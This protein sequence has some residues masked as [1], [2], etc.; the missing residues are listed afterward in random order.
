MIALVPA[1][2]GSKGL[3]R[4]NILPLAGVPLIVHTLKC[5]LAATEISRVVVSTDDE[6]IASVAADIEGVEVPFMRPAELAADTA[7]AID[8]YLHAAEALGV[9][10]LCVLLP[11]APLRTPEDI[12]ACIRLFRAQKAEVV[13]SVNEAKP[14]AWQQRMNLGGQLAPV[15]GIVPSIDNR[16]GYGVTVIPNGAIYVLNMPSLAR[17]RSYFGAKS[18]GHL[19]PAS[20]SVDIDDADDFTVAEALLAYRGTA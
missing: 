9:G 12:D 17:T 5:A 4:K 7:S 14:A 2:G 10:E 13:M 18:L 1:R 6:E 20:R 16:Q 11:T 8:A 3:P 15:P 19:M